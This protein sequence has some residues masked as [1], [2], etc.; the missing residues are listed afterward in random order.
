MWY[1]RCGD[2]IKFKPNS[3]H[4]KGWLSPMWSA[5]LLCADLPSISVNPIRQS[6]HLGVGACLAMFL[7]HWIHTISS[8][9]FLVLSFWCI[10]SDWCTTV[11]WTESQSNS[12]WWRVCLLGFLSSVLKYRFVFLNQICQIVDFVTVSPSRTLPMCAASSMK[13]FDNCVSSAEPCQWSLRP[14]CRLW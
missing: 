1:L 13:S 9:P 5:N 14:Q 2:E 8:N 6:G 11:N 4:L 3:W 12:A 7:Y 10:A